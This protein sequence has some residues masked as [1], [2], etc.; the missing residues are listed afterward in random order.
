MGRRS[1]GWA[2]VAV[3]GRAAVIQAFRHVGCA[4]GGRDGRL[5]L[6][7]AEGGSAGRLQAVRSING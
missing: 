7:N 1:G 6:S 4:P 2:S 3:R 5:S